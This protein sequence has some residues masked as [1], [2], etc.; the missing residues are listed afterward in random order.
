MAFNRDI[1]AVIEFGLSTTNT[2]IL[3]CYD[4]KY[5]NGLWN[6]SMEDFCSLYTR[7]NSP[8]FHWRRNYYLIH[9]DPRDDYT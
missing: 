4:I 3:S 6:H 9:Y 2:E 8:T 1:K 5:I 7:N